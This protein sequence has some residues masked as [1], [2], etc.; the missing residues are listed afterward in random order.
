MP[1]LNRQG[2]PTLWY[3]LDDYTNPWEKAPAIVLQHGFGRSSRIWYSWVPYLS[4]YYRVI[5]PDLRGL[6][7]SSR[8]FDVQNNL[9]LDFYMDDMEA[10]LDEVGVERAHYCGESFGGLLGMAFAAKRPSRFRTLSLLSAPVYISDH[11]KQSTTYGHAS[12]IDALRH[13]GARAWAQASNGG[14][15]F[16]VDADPGLLKWY[17]DLMGESDVEVL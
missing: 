4:R 13:M 11:D 17:V 5:R 14:R 12:R 1:Y 8:A 15:R 7:R 2:N 16:P 10:I 3:D 9:G 6:G